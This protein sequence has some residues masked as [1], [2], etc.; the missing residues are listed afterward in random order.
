MLKKNILAT[1]S[2]YLS[3]AHK[4]KIIDKYLFELNKIFKIISQYENGKKIKNLKK[5]PAP[6]TGFQR[7]N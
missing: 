4:K 6:H 5:L 3:I 7:L 1:D 2:I